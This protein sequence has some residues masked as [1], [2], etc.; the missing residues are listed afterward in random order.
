ME[1]GRRPQQGLSL[2]DLVAGC[3]RVLARTDHLALVD[4]AIRDFAAAAP[5][6]LLEPPAWTETGMLTGTDEELVAWLLAYNAI[7]FCYWRDDATRWFVR[8]GGEPMG[9]DD[10]ALGVMGAFAEA[11]RQRVPLHDG[12]FLAALDATTL[13]RLLAPAPGAGALP[14]M[15]ERL[16]GL[17]ELGRAYVAWGG[18]LGL[19]DTGGS[20]VALVERLLVTCPSW[21]D[22]RLFAGEVLTFAK[23]AQLCVAMI[24]GR[25]LRAGVGAFRDLHRLTAFADYRLPQVLRGAGIL[26]LAPELAARIDRGE[27]I[28]AGTAAEVALR[29]A[30]VAG[31]ERIR[32]ALLPRAPRADAL[33]VD[34]LLWRTAVEQQDH[35]P[36]FHRT[37]T[38]AY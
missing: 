32:V 30:A 17:R 22:A 34:H 27:E 18:P 12:R 26:Q 1:L 19:V 21:S 2:I 6:R 23:R 9:V 38:T 11:I 35:L 3:E 24:A 37:R 8:V 29:A 20:A 4:E 16:A 14:L 36:A 15:P 33:V 28:P 25:F 31:A 13:E 10:E 5:A 7:N